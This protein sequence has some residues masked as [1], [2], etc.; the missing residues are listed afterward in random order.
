MLSSSQLE[1]PAAVHFI[2]GPLRNS[3]GHFS[4]KCLYCTKNFNVIDLNNEVF[5]DVET[6]HDE[7]IYEFSDNN[8][9]LEI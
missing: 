8:Y 7:S 9:D 3:K 6:N 4:A 1:R 2:K 5:C